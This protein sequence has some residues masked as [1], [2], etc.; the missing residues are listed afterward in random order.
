MA[1]R[2]RPPGAWMSDLGARFG[3]YLLLAAL[4]VFAA[5]TTPEFLTQQN[6]ANVVNQTAALAILALGQTFV[7]AA[8]LIDLSVGQ[9]LGLV[10]VLTCDFMGGVPERAAPA[11]AI[12][13]ALGGAIGLVNG[14]LHNWLRIHPLILTFGMLSVLQGAIFT[15]TDKSVGQASPAILWLANSALGGVPIALLLLV[16]VA[17]FGSHYL[18]KHTRFGLHLRATGAHEE[19][20]RRAGIRVRRV[21][22]AAFAISGL[23]AGMAGILV[24]GRLGTGYPNAGNEFELNAIVAV[25]LGGTSFAGGRGTMA[26]TLAAVLVLGLISNM[27][28]LLEISAF[29]Q[30]TIKGAIVVA[31]ILANQPRRAVA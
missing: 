20:A 13:L 7:I 24:A 17:G 18:F 22:L 15:Y 16:A 21:A 29:V 30:T 5:A 8:G 4:A 14:L 31:A 25:V 28:N 9:L 10:A 23:S 26:G 12:A 19:S 3:I 27:L 6:L 11:I 1:V 2:E